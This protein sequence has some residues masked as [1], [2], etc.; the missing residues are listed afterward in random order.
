MNKKIRILLNRITNRMHINLHFESAESHPP[1]TAAD[2]LEKITSGEYTR[3]FCINVNIQTLMEPGKGMNA[4]KCFVDIINKRLAEEN[5][6]HVLNDTISIDFALEQLNKDLEKPTLIIFHYFQY[7]DD[8]KGGK[9]KK[10][11]KEKKLL[12]PLRKFIEMIPSIY[13]KILIISRQP[14]ENWDLQ[15]D[16]PLDD[17]LVKSIDWNLLEK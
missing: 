16:S 17:G 6:P 2:I 5:S 12:T 8:R 4:V 10:N 13:L 9:E 11:E 3:D 1:V 14:T 15:P 7:P